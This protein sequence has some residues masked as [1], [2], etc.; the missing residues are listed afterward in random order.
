ME[1]AIIGSQFFGR[2]NQEQFLHGK[3][4]TLKDGAAYIYSLELI[5][6]I[7][8]INLDGIPEAEALRILGVD[9]KGND[10]RALAAKQAQQKAEQAQQADVIAAIPELKTLHDQ[11]TKLTAERVTA[12]FEKDLAAL[13]TSYLGGLERKMTELKQKGDLDGVLALEA[14]KQNVGRVFNS[15]SSPNELKTRSTSMPIPAE[16]DDAT[17]ANLKALRKIYRDTFAKHEATRAAN[18]KLLTDPLTLRLKQLESTLTQKNRIEHAKTVRE[19]REGLGRADGPPSAANGPA[20]ANTPNPA[21]AGASAL[22]KKKFPPGDDLKAAEWVLSV[23]GTLNIFGDYPRITDAAEL[24]RGR[25]EVT[26]VYLEFSAAKRPL[27]PINDLL[28]LAGLKN[29]ARLHLKELPLEDAH[30]E[31]I[32]SLPALATLRMEKAGISNNFFAHLADSRLQS[33]EFKF[34]PHITGEGISALRSCK[35]LNGIQLEGC[36]PTEEGLQQIGS[37]EFLTKLSLAHSYSRLQ[38]EHLPLL[39]GLKKLKSLSLRRT[40]VTAEGL[41]AVKAWNSLTDLGFDLKP[42]DGVAQVAVLAAAFPKLEAFSIEGGPGAPYSAEDLRALNGFPRLREFR[43]TTSMMTDEIL[44][45]LLAVDGLESLVFINA[46]KLTDASLGTVAKLR[47]LK[48]LEITGCPNLTDT[49]IAAF[50][51]ARPD[52]TVVR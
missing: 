33:L 47:K 2:Y 12:P 29:L 27:A 31:V 5:R 16:D 3:D 15:S 34:E 48:R 35:E 36:Q 41:A 10:L 21:L 44:P 24:P 8:V 1:F 25:F 52:V 38:D 37:L 42:G 51:K 32:P 19:Y 14:E 17:P 49:A 23:G 26:A 18:L 4:D 45:G 13:N 20:G 50:Q 7:E 46:T 43:S 22:P 40:Q 6:D 9:E 30:L 11:L 39:A 28:P